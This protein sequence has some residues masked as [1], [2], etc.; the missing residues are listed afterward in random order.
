MITDIKLQF[1]AFDTP[2][3]GWVNTDITPH[4][5]ISRITGF[6]KLL[7]QLGLISDQRLSQHRAGIFSQLRYLNVAKPFPFKD[8]SVCCIYSSHMLEHL[9]QHIARGCL[10]ESHR[11]LKPGG[12]LRI[13]VPDLD[14]M[15]ADYRPA[16]PDAW[17]HEIFALYSKGDKNRHWWHYNEVSLKQKLHDVGFEDCYRCGLG[18][19]RCVDVGKFEAADNHEGCPT[20]FM[21]AIKAQPRN[22][23]NS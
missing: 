1:R 17:L 3:S 5:F 16:D 15:I 11:V 12:V 18:E 9:P 8:D 22:G 10:N 14:Q 20:L 2:I 4:M 7:N 6:P 13:A 19:G 23:S 21:E